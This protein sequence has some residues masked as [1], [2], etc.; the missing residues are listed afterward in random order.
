MELLCAS[1]SLP[2]MWIKIAQA[3]W[4]Y[5]KD[6]VDEPVQRAGFEQGC[7]VSTEALS[8]PA[9]PLPSRGHSTQVA[10]LWF[11]CSVVGTEEKALTQRG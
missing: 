2:K 6:S 3:S 7:V 10:V 4:S 5:C 9:S 11:W 1:V 8:G